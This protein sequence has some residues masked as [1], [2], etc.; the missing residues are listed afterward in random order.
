LMEEEGYDIDYA[1][2]KLLGLDICTCQDSA[3]LCKVTE[4]LEQEVS[5]E[6]H[7]K[8]A[9]AMSPISS[10]I[11]FERNLLLLSKLLSGITRH[12]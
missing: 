6:S 5:D 11:D 3:T 7:S 10:D 4:I 1:G 9:T 8:L 12:S 2:A